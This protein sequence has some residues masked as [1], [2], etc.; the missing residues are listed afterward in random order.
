MLMTVILSLHT[1][2]TGMYTQSIG[3]MK[4]RSTQHLGGK[5]WYTQVAWWEPMRMSS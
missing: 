3:L 1:N 2:K 4:W 5:L